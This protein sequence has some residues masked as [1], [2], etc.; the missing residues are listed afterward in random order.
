MSKVGWIGLHRK[1]TEHWIFPHLRKYTEFEA[2]LYILLHTNFNDSKVQEG[3][4]IYTINRGQMLTS[5]QKLGFVWLW[6]RS[7]VRRFLEMLAKDGMIVK[8][9]TSKFTII[10]VCKYESYQ[11]FRTATEQ[12]LNNK[13]TSTEQQLNTSEEGKEVKESKKV[14]EDIVSR[15]QK[16]ASTIEPYLQKYGRNLLNDFYK[17]WTEPNKSNTKFRQELEKTWD[18]ERRLETWSKNDKNFSHGTHQQTSTTGKQSRSQQNAESV[19][20]LLN[21]LAEDMQRIA[22]EN[23]RTEI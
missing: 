20:Y 22:G 1:I 7:K 11:D 19:S 16:F 12:Q 6:D 23:D 15:K 4:T 18:L 13:R 5:E 2:W 3:N 8:K 9:S 14:K 10:T 17:Y 21:S